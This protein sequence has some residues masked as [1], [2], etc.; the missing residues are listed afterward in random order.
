MKLDR[1][2]WEGTRGVKKGRR[3][4]M[5]QKCQAG[6]GDRRAE[7]RNRDGTEKRKTTNMN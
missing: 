3:S 5:I 1:E 4:H 6:T 7:V 2:P